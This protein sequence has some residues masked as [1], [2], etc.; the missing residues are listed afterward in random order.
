MTC[1]HDDLEV[2]PAHH[3]KRI[4]TPHLIERAFREERRRTTTIPRFFDEKSFLKLAYT[5]L[6]QASQRWQKVRMSELEIMMLKQLRRE[7]GLDPQP[8]KPQ[9]LED[10][11]KVS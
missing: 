5:T 3:H 6:W 7:L 9:H 10:L 1:L 2:C 8:L 4:C 11:R